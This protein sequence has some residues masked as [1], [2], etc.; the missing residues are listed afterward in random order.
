MLLLQQLALAPP[1]P[2]LGACAAAGILALV[3]LGQTRHPLPV[4][5]FAGLA[6]LCAGFSYAGWR[7]Q[8]R[9]ADEVAPGV[10]G[11]D[12]RVRGF[13][14]SLPS[15]SAG[16]TRFVFSVEEIVSGPA[17]LPRVVSVGW[18]R[19]D[20]AVQPAQRWEFTLRIHR[21]HAALNPAGF[22]A[23][24]WMFEQGVRAVGYVRDGPHDEPPRKL[25]ERVADF[26]AL[27][28]RARSRLRERLERLLGEAR[29]RG[30]IVALVM[31]DQGQIGE[32]DWTLFNRTAISHLVSISGL[33]ITMIAAL[34]AWACGALWRRSARLLRFATLPVVRS[35]AAILAGLAYCLLAGWGVPAQRT[36]IMLSVAALARCARASPPPATVLSAACALVCLWDPWA[37]LQ[38]GF[39]LSFGAVACIFLAGAGHV[40]PPRGWKETLREGVYLQAAITVGQVPL[41]AAIFG[42]VSLVGPAANAVAIPLV[43][44]VVAPLALAGAAIVSIADGAAPVGQLLLVG[45]ERVF[46]AL[47]WFL[48]E[49]AS[50]SWATPALPLPPAWAVVAAAAGVAWTVHHRE[51]PLRLAGG[52]LLLP[53]LVLPAPAPPAG[54]LWV[55]ALDVGQGMGVV[56]ESRKA[57]VVFDTGPRYA[58]EADAGSRVLIPYL[59]SRAIPRIDLLVV[60][61]Q[62]IDHAGGAR[63]LLGSMP[64]DRILSSVEATNPLLAGAHGV[65]RCEA[66]A[67][68]RAGDIDLEVLSPP[69]DLYE[70]RSSTNSRSCVLRAS[71]G[72]NSVLL[73]GDIPAR[74]EARMA[75]SFVRRPVRLMLAPHHGSHSS[76]SEALL[77]WASP[78][79]VS[80]QAGY[81]SRFGHPHPSVVARTLAHGACIVRSDASGAARW[82]FSPDGAV[83]VERWRIEH[84][85]YWNDRMPGA[86]PQGGCDDGVP[87]RWDAPG[88]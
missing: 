76:S 22:D 45:A 31:G 74:E 29:Y 60:S 10:E 38:A 2:A 5:A 33:H 53:L 7:A 41:T 88:G 39:W 43:S 72:G 55:T 84:A 51:W 57:V 32:A 82:K 16:A 36:L 14:A 65:L 17:H 68:L 67:H 49:L 15:V 87:P 1:L 64:V 56:L 52:M 30:V 73:T 50:R 80:I 62:D 25:S 8:A 71:L 9:L 18:Y 40:G 6:A 78:H 23:E 37:P 63:S 70:R 12:L 11:L 69:A 58:P 77:S 61:H 54:G 34:G 48:G 59:R 21:P 35:V 47:A 26:N 19:Q 42:Q 46:A 75:Q 44:Y 79:W 28:D 27:V 20:A 81:R 24:G 86:G 66:G 4:L 13:V 83:Q 85:R 3:F